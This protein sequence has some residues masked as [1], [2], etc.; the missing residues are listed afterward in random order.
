MH[1][2]LFRAS[3]RQGKMSKR[4]GGI[5]GRNAKTNTYI[6]IYILRQLIGFLDGSNNT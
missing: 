1:I 2:N 4:S 5:I 3:L 6:Y